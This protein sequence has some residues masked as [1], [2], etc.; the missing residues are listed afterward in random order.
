MAEPVKLLGKAPKQEDQR[1]LM[2]ARY[3]ASEFPAKY[4]WQKKRKP[5][6]S[7][8]FGNTEYGD[9][10]LASQANALIRMERIE[11]RRTVLIPDQ[12]VISNYLE[13]TGGADSGWYELDA[14]KRW[15]SNGFLYRSDRRYTIDAFAEIHPTNT[16]EMKAALWQFKVIKVCFGLPKAWS[17]IDPP[18]FGSSPATEGAWDVGV[19]PD[20]EPYSWGGHS[21]MADGYDENGLWVAHTWYH[22]PKPARQLVTWEAVRKY[23]D[24]SYSIID[25]FDGWRKKAAFDVQQ[26]QK[27]VE[28]VTAE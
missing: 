24:E 3:L 26:L 14:L 28:K 1:N 19:G 13:M 23:A 10:T 17:R 2:A 9:C 18:G 11:Q 5:A 16:D 21:M 20:Y 12:T 4:D 7:R 22:A 15:R 25:S 6:P 27:D 8:T